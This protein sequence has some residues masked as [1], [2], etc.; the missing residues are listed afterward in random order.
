MNE[1]KRTSMI[2]RAMAA[3]QGRIVFAAALV[4]AL[5]AGVGVFHASTHVAV[6]RAG[7]DLGKVTTTCDA[8]QREN[9]HLKLERA[10]LR[11][12]PRLE[13]IA[14]ARLGLVAPSAGQ[15][16]AMKTHKLSTVAREQ[17]TK[18]ASAA[19]PAPLAQNP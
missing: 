6:V 13:A 14:R 15:I 7:Y 18:L 9:E 1:L 2:R 10:T 3:G 17:P 8:L 19:T 11:S 5:F 16:V 12:A 4:T